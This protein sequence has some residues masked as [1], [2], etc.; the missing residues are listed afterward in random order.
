MGSIIRGTLRLKDRSAP[1][2]SLRFD[3]NGYYS[4][5]A[6]KLC[7][8]GTGSPIFA[9]SSKFL[10]V[11]KLNYPKNSS[12]YDSLVTGTLECIAD[13]NYFE[14]ISILGLSQKSG[15]QPT[16]I[17]K[18]RL[19][20]SLI[21]YD[22]GESLALDSLS[23]SSRGFCGLLSS[24]LERYELE[25]GSDCW[26]MNCSPLGGDAGYVPTFFVFHKTRCEDGKFQMLL[27]FPDS[28]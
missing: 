26:G 3:L 2:I 25:Y 9:G 14:P 5:S 27:G 7:M 12:V 6:K 4:D 28:R 1:V 16:F 22:G 11:L 17:G 20:G 8:V 15:Y 13:K 24:G 10:V 18:G 23:V 19:N 21:G